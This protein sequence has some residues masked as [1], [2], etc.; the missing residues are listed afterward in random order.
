MRIVEKYSRDFKYDLDKLEGENLTGYEEIEI[1]GDDIK[2]WLDTEY[3]AKQIIDFAKEIE[4]KLKDNDLDAAYEVLIHDYDEIP[5]L[6]DYIED[7]I[8]KSVKYEYAIR[9]QLDYGEDSFKEDDG[10]SNEEDN[11]DID[12]SEEDEEENTELTDK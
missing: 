2:H 9:N 3:T 4:P 10:F 11:K 6:D 8:Y 1:N 12:F 7:E 5:E